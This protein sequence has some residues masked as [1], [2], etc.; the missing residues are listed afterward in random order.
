MSEEVELGYWDWLLK[1]N[2]RL[3]LI[4]LSIKERRGEI[5]EGDRDVLESL[6]TVYELGY[7]PFYANKLILPDETAEAQGLFN[8]ESSDT[9]GGIEFDYTFSNNKTQQK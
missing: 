9:G 4:L 2:E 3:S 7:L 1:V 6:H 5:T 8:S